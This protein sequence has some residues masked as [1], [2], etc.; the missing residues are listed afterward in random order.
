LE[1]RIEEAK[2]RA[3]SQK[4]GDKGD[5]YEKSEHKRKRIKLRKKGRR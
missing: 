1:K 3:R 4:Y 5:F 2:I